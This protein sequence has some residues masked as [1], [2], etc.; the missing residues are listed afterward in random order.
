MYSHSF[1]LTPIVRT[2]VAGFVEMALF[3]SIIEH[4]R[5]GDFID[6]ALATI[7]SYLGTINP[8]VV[9]SLPPSLV[10][11]VLKPLAT[12]LFFEAIP[13]RDPATAAASVTPQAAKAIREGHTSITYVTPDNRVKMWQAVEGFSSSIHNYKQALSKWKRL[14]FVGQ[15]RYEFQVL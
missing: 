7:N 13:L 8:D 3:N 6:M 15:N 9:Y 2:S 10:D 1:G 11:T 12:A 4:P 5:T 14:G